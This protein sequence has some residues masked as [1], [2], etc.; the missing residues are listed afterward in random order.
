[1]C[2]SVCVSVCE[3]EF[4]Q[5][6]RVWRFQRLF[7]AWKGAVAESKREATIVKRVVQRMQQG[8]LVRCFAKLVQ[9]GR[10]RA[11]KRQTLGSLF[12]VLQH[13]VL[14]RRLHRWCVAVVWAVVAVGCGCGCCGCGCGCV[15][16]WQ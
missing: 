4:T 11:A 10:F 15:A 5:R 8:T 6:W 9:L 13:G 2:V 7:E 1:M 12:R 3:Q 14:R 16:V